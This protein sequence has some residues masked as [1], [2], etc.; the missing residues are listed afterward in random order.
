MSNLNTNN[1]MKT[2]T[3]KTSKLNNKKSNSIIEAAKT[4]QRSAIKLRDAKRGLAIKY[5]NS[6][7]VYDV[8]KKYKDK[9]VIKARQTGREWTCTT[10]RDLDHKVLIAQ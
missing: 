10:K 3:V 1:A 4:I 2:K 6:D 5:A 8:L 7:L 9:V